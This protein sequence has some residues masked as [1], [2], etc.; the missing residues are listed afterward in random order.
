LAGLWVLF[1]QLVRF[2]CHQDAVCRTFVEPGSV[3]DFADAQ[4]FVFESE[5]VHDL[6]RTI[7]NLNAIASR[8]GSG[9]VMAR[10]FYYSFRHKWFF[11]HVSYHKT[12]FRINYL[13][14]KRQSIYG[15]E[16]LFQDMGR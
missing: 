6:R 8:S 14:D 16:T 1:D 3:A 10:Q 9:P 15:G 4:L 12:L 7:E 13:T 11:L 5:A 2:Q